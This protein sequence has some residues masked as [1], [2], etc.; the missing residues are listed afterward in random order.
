MII[1]NKGSDDYGV[2]MVVML[3]IA[4]AVVVP[5]SSSMYRQCV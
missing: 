5:Y 4:A 3:I 1:I 2:D